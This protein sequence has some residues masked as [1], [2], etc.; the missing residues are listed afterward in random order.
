MRF[1]TS[2]I[3]PAA[4]RSRRMGR[5]K[6]LLPFGE[7][8]VL[9]ATL[10]A[11]ATGGADRI[12]VVTRGDDRRL[13]AWLRDGAAREPDDPVALVHAVNPDP[14]RGMLSSIVAG[15]EALGGEPREPVLVCPADLPALS[16]GTVTA[17]LEALAS[18]ESSLAVPVHDG[19]RGH[20]LAVTPRLLPEIP[21][22]DLE[23]GLRQLLA[24]HPGEVLEV[25]VEDPGCVRDVDT[26]ADYRALSG[27]RPSS[28]TSE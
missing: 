13:A 27:A 3:V 26:P 9:G 5:P 10:G 15:L 19:R 28:R 20:P 12:V 17:V 14:A 1:M 18:S 7:G 8:T 24:R 4:G 2:A 23:V 25:E 6:L 11:L 22:L 21:G 16:P